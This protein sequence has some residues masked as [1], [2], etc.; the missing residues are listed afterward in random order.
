MVV[1]SGIVPLINFSGFIGGSPETRKEIGDQIFRA[2]RDVGFIY[3]QNHGIPQEDVDECFKWSKK[4]FAMPEENKMKCP[5]PPSGSHHRGYSSIGKERVSQ[6]VFDESK[7]QELRKKPDMK[8]S[9]DLG[10]EKDIY[11]NFWPDESDI[12]GFREFMLKF[13]STA[14]SASQNVLRA[15]ALGMGLEEEYFIS[16]HNEANNQLRL[17][18]YPPAKEDELKTGDR[19][20]I[21]AHSDFGTMT[22]LMQDEV[23]GLEVEDPNHPGVFHPAPYIPGTIVINI[24]DFLMRWSNDILRSTLHRVRAPPVSTGTGYTKERYSIPY[25][26]TA[27]RNTVIDCLPGC[28][29]ENNPK[30]YTPICARE[31]IEMRLNA[32]Y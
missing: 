30:K 25:F 11:C 26:V 7:L 6:M 29:S 28:W 14:A 20:R 19:D 31:Y 23:G 1:D 5:H 3:L 16:F 12:P 22:L 10:K 15:I 27:N 32:T 17:L 13:H 8:E 21:A 24:G 18:H 9:F 4:F 2:M